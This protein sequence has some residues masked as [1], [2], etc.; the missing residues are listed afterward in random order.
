M[1]KIV[2]K[3][4]D[5]NANILY[6]KNE[7]V[8]DTSKTQ[9]RIEF[10]NMAY[11]TIT[12][13]KFEAKGYNVF[14]DE[15]QI[16]G[17]PTFDIVVQDLAIAPKKYAKIESILPSRDIRKL[18]LKLK[19][20]YYANGKIIDAL[21]EDNVTYQVEELNGEKGQQEKE[22]K[23][24]LEKKNIEAICF[25]KKYGRKW[26]CICGYLNNNT[27][28]TCKNCGCRQVDVFETCTEDAVY[29]TLRIQHEQ[30]KVRQEQEKARL[31][32]ER[33]KRE[34]EQQ[35]Q[36]EQEKK[37]KKKVFLMRSSGIIAI[38][39]VVIAGVLM[40][41]NK[42]GLSKEESL[43]YEIAESNYKKIEDFCLVLGL[44]FSDK[45][46][47]YYDNDYNR[48]RDR[49]N[50]AEKDKD[51]LYSRGI[52]EASSLLYELILDQYPEK[53]RPIYA[54]L[55]KTHIGEIFN[56][57]DI[58]ETLYVKNMS[59]SSYIDKGDEIDETID[60]LEK[61]MKKTVLNP[62]NV[63]YTLPSMPDADYSNVYG[64][65]LGIIYYDDGNIMY[66]GEMGD[67][68]AD[69]FGEAWYSSEDGNRFMHKGVFKKGT[70]VSGVVG[71]NDLEDNVLM[72]GKFEMVTGLNNTDTSESVANQRVN[73]EKR[74][75]KK[76]SACA[77]QYANAVVN[78]DNG[79]SKIEW[80]DIPSVS[81]S[82]YSYSCTVT[83]SDNST[84]KG[85]ITVKKDTDGSFSAVGL[86]LE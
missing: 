13:V 73:D 61:Y 6:L 56:D 40:Y 44:E 83:M 35:K 62:A 39:L 20:V 69:G 67:G 77:K 81:G 38:C 80:Y 54:D 30:E 2:T 57:I 25:P 26:I 82:Y 36:A 70:Y 1:G 76:A 3:S 37:R 45:C 21:P 68:K 17:K 66:I 23:A 52:Y 27:D 79:C 72:E 19:Q 49:S 34:E 42:Y 63:D 10:R 53:Y 78:K 28:V 60:S 51:F 29:D 75:K 84:R 7:I 58:E 48:R 5:M 65:S 16:D 24:F 22:A 9:A 71:S 85:T 15:I 4:V 11:G 31:E 41:R 8:A 55:V 59:A 46:N 43:V 33:V 14:G 64:I 50:D 47:G 32:A 18:D 12:A 86:D 74:D